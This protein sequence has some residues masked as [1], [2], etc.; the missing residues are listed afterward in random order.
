MTDWDSG[1]DNNQYNNQLL[2]SPQSL[3]SLPSLPMQQLPAQQLPAQQL[4]AQQLPAQQ[5]QDSISM[6]ESQTVQ[7]PQKLMT[8][9]QKSHSVES[10]NYTLSKATDIDYSDEKASRVCKPG[11]PLASNKRLP[12]CLL[13][14]DSI[15]LR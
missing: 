12:N 5:P 11:P 7:E 6:Q 15:T 1:F 13:I 2:E 3:Q 4:P 14:G 8:S 10:L 9:H